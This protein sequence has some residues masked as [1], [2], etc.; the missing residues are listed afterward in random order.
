MRVALYGGSFN[1]PHR[2]HE[3]A[4][5]AL[6]EETKPDRVF[7]IPAGAPPHKKIE[8]AP[9]AELRLRL[10]REAFLPLSEKIEVWD[11]ELFSGKVNYTSETVRFFRERFPGD[12]ILFLT[13]TDM[14]LS[15]DTW[16]RADYLFENLVIVCMP[17][18]EETDAIL[19]KKAYYEAEFHAKILLLSEKPII[20]SSSE[21]R[22]EIERFGSSAALSPAVNECVALNFLYGAG[23]DETKRRILSILREKL[24]PERV[25]HTLSVERE[26]VRLCRYLGRE[27]LICGMSRAALLHDLFRHSSPEE[28]TAYLR[29]AGKTAP[30][31]LLDPPVLL[32]GFT[33]SVF[34]EKEFALPPEYAR[35]IRFHTTGCRD[36]ALCDQILYLADG[37]EETRVQ[38]FLQKARRDFWD[39][40]DGEAPETHLKKAC[41]AFLKGSCEHE[42]EKGKT[43]H[44]DT[45]FA[46][47]SLEKESEK[48]GST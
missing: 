9:P 7:V 4:L 48:D 8:C 10:C 27:D 42:K 41:L 43:V 6:M 11:G 22:K 28:Q 36:M 31:D 20:I 39:G 34:A 37:I 21:V 3:R 15:F 38:P 23:R 35:A 14:F 13:G 33:A 1:P 47:E 2:G 25:R 32:H 46:I 30:R 17:R 5:C 18:D 29:S 45:L 16:H 19:K 26:C 44:P 24:P 12:E 40:A